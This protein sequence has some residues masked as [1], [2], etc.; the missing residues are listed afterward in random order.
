MV[1]DDLAFGTLIQTWLKKKGFDVVRAT[2]VKAALQLLNEDSKKDLILSD[3]RLPDHDGLTL[4][5]WIQKHNMPIPFIVMTS[6]AEVQNAV[7]AMKSGATDYIAKP[8]QPDILLEKIQDAL[9][10]GHTSQ[11]DV[12]ATAGST[13]ATTVATSANSKSTTI[14]KENDKS[15]Y[16][17]GES[18][19]SKQLYSFVSLVAPTPCRYSFWVQAERVR[20]ILPD[21]FTN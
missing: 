10:S 12:T 13:A 7:L 11:P 8:F 20:N 17:E 18:E 1:E 4:L 6:Y 15:K 2:S 16:I 21:V 3:L 9:K 19:A 14:S 5:N